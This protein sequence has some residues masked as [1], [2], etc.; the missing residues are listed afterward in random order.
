VR[1]GIELRG[2][3]D[4][5]FASS[6]AARQSAGTCRD[7]H[8]PTRP[9]SARRSSAGRGAS[10]GWLPAARR[11]SCRCAG[12]ACSHGR[13]A[14]VVERIFF[15]GGLMD[16]AVVLI[17]TDLVGAQDTPAIFGSYRRRIP[18]RSLGVKWP[19]PRSV[20]ATHKGRLKRNPAPRR[21]FSFCGPPRHFQKEMPNDTS[22]EM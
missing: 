19:R 16:L 13:V 4:V 18:S 10:K 5:P 7:A 1:P 15:C 12:S 14:N 11:R 17:C 8:A 9:Q 2:E 22:P 3:T 6:A 21:P 20:K